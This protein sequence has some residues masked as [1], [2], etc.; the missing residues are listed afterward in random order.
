MDYYIFSY[1]VDIGQITKAFGSND[2]LLF[3]NIQKGEVFKNY[4]EQNADPY[5]SMTK[6]LHQ[7]IFNEPYRKR[8]ENVYWYA[9]IALCEYFSR[10]LPYAQDIILGRETDLI[11]EFV[12]DDFNIDLTTVEVFLNGEPEVN[13]PPPDGIP[14]VGVIPQSKMQS[15]CRMMN[16]IIINDDKIKE[17]LLRNNWQNEERVLIYETIR[18]VQSNINFCNNHH[19]TLISFCH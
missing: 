2:L 12:K 7:I 13:L 18:G 5:I 1:A 17:L 10:K 14:M 8:S 3:E 6:A 15:V 19:L 4:S 16:K 9:F 11:D